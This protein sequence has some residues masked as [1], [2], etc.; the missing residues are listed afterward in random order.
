MEDPTIC[1]AVAARQPIVSVTDADSD[2]LTQQ[3]LINVILF[4]FVAC[5]KQ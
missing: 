1:H 5:D 3:M 2:S 4:L